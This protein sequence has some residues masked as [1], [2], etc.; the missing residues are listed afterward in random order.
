MD[1][2]QTVADGPLASTRMRQALLPMH[3]AYQHSKIQSWT[4]MPARAFRSQLSLRL[5]D[6]VHGGG[7]P[8]ELGVPGNAE[9]AVAK[10][11][12]HGGG[13]ADLQKIISL[14]YSIDRM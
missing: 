3:F 6:S 5:G 2:G 7:Q 14:L 4:T 11:R 13:P 9:L 1:V 12:Q 10:E 8:A